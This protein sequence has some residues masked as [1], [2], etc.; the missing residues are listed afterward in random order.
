MGQVEEF[1]HL[2]REVVFVPVHG[3][4]GIDDMPDFFDDGHFFFL[5]AVLIDDIGE[6]PDVSALITSFAGDLDQFIGVG[7]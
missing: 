3:T 6:M 5:G 1:G 2:V 7:V 4:V